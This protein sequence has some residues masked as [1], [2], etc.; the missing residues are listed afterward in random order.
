[1]KTRFTIGIAVTLLVLIGLALGLWWKFQPEP[2]V[3][4]YEPIGC[5]YS[6]TI[7]EVTAVPDWTTQ[8]R[9]EARSIDKE[10]FSPYTPLENVTLDDQ[11]LAWETTSGK[12]VVDNEIFSDLQFVDVTGF[13]GDLIPFVIGQVTETDLKDEEWRTVLEFLLKSHVI[14]T[15]VHLEAEV[16]LAEE[17][18]S[19]TEYS[20]YFSAVHRYCTSDCYEEPYAFTVKVNKQTGNI[21]IQ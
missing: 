4:I 12:V 5:M 8:T 2:N 19:D 21:S 10:K 9:L 3:N 6:E 17:V 1:M 13:T 14:K 20:A 18:N 11:P 15:Y 7:T 16:C